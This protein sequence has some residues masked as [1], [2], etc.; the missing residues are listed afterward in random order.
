MARQ[1]VAQDP[2]VEEVRLFGSLAK[3]NYTPR[4]DADICIILG[5]DDPRRMIDRIPEFRESFRGAPVPVDILVYTR[6]EMDQM[7][8]EG[9]RFAR[10]L[11]E[12]SIVLASER[13][14]ERDLSTQD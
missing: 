4:S 9:R 11:A 1:L 14:A 5:G 12:H 2:R 13:Q 3:G 7:R 6:A 10:E 8:Q